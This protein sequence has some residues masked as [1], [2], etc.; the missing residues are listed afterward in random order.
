MP[1]SVTSGAHGSAGP[2]ERER[3]PLEG[4]NAKKGKVIK[5][6]RKGAKATAVK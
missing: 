1:N 3:E 2:S 4:F 5:K 6:G